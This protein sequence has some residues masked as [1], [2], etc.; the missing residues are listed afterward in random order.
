MCGKSARKIDGRVQQSSISILV[1][2]ILFECF[3]FHFSIFS[4]RSRSL[5]HAHFHFTLVYFFVSFECYCLRTPSELLLMLCKR[6]S[7]CVCRVERLATN[8]LIYCLVCGMWV[9]AC[10]KWN[11]SYHRFGERIAQCKPFDCLIAFNE[12]CKLMEST[13]WNGTIFRDYLLLSFRLQ[14]NEDEGN[15]FLMKCRCVNHTYVGESV[16][17]CV[18]VFDCPKDWCDMSYRIKINAADGHAHLICIFLVPPSS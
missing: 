17:L 2:N 9:C 18:C 14:L 1:T 7:V 8:Y 10:C 15:F 13:K 5:F 11:D 4:S 6:C 3:F 16:S 12:E